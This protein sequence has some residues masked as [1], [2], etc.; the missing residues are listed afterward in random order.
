M[1]TTKL[2]YQL[3]IYNPLCINSHVKN[4]ICNQKNTVLKAVFRIFSST[5][6]NNSINT[7]FST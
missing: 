2:S 4:A 6:Q 7:Y 3:N 5:K 1:Y